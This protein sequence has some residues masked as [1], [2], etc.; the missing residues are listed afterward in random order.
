ME[1]AS[2][3]GVTCVGFSES[4]KCLD[5]T[6]HLTIALQHLA[7]IRHRVCLKLSGYE[8]IGRARNHLGANISSSAQADPRLWT[9]G[10]SS[11]RIQRNLTPLRFVLFVT[12][13][14]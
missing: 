2:M 14:C 13:H 10:D 6:V 9:N 12:G 3:L 5:F 7:E 4:V 11:Y 8:V 1:I